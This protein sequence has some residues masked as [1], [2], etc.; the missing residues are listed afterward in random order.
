MRR[1]RHGRQGEEG[2]GTVAATLVA[3]RHAAE[4]GA[5]R[6][7]WM[8]KR[9]NAFSL[10]AGVRPLGRAERRESRPV[11]HRRVDEPAV[12]G[13]DR[14][15]KAHTPVPG[16]ACCFGRQPA[17]VAGRGSS[18][19]GLLCSGTA[20]LDSLPRDRVRQNHSAKTPDGQGTGD[21]RVSARFT[22]PGDRLAKL[23]F[24][25]EIPAAIGLDRPKAVPV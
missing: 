12:A 20:S 9:R 13:G 16:P 21:R 5:A 23:A 4:R 7:E 1:G 24:R 17:A 11:L 3:A 25:K 19:A 10:T 15:A 2:S 8:S 14:L 22:R 18:P 6:G